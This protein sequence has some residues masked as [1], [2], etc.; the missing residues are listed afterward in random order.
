MVWKHEKGMSIKCIAYN[1]N[2]AY[3]AYKASCFRNQHNLLKTPADRLTFMMLN[4]IIGVANSAINA[5]QQLKYALEKSPE[6][7]I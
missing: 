5:F 6:Y 1:T 2:K 3:K 7:I 4:F